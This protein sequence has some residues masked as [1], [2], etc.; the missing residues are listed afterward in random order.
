[1]DLKKAVVTGASGF[2]GSYLVK[3]LSE[4]GYHVLAVV[5]PATVNKSRIQNIDHVKIVECDLFHLQQL[6]SSENEQYD[7]FFHMGWVGVSGKEH[8]DYK[9]QMD[10]IQAALIAMDVAKAL[11]CKRFIGA[12]SLHE[13]ECKIEM[14]QNIEVK[15]QGNAYKIAKL[16]AHYYCKLKAS[17]IGIDFLWPLL[18]NTYGVGET[19]ARLLNS[20]I[21]ELLQGKEPELTKGD[22]LYNFIYVS[23]AARAYRLIAEKGTSYQ[24]YIIGSEDVHP[25][26]DFLTEI[27]MI[28]N[29]NV[30]LGFGKHQFSGV[31]LKESDLYCENLFQI[32]FQ[33]KVPFKKGII[34]TTKWIS[35]CSIH[36]TD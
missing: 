31:Y 9:I 6:L 22:Q 12:G 15:N 26:K 5:R 34:E 35:D 32:G 29:P 14:E 8:S 20:V 2:I 27:Q 33:T 36:P 30:P 28:V 10:N 23:D 17:A 16:A 11:G 18:T 24:K 7:F 19:S 13:L 3:E 1:M 4:N 21:R 25:L